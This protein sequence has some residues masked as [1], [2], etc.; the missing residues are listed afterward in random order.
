MP[1]TKHTDTEVNIQ[2]YND[3]NIIRLKVH[4]MQSFCF[5][6][7]QTPDTRVRAEEH[8]KTTDDVFLA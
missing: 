1:I 6:Q 4:V 7:W 3:P 5:S 8:G 2:N